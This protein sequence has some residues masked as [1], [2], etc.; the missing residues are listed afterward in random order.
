MEKFS[1]NGAA[2]GSPK[3]E[4]SDE[5]ADRAGR[6]AYYFGENFERILRNVAK[7]KTNPRYD[8]NA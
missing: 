4:I 7:D 5:T 6:V 2:D 8:F 1:E 3:L